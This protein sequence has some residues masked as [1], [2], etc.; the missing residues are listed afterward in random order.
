MLY[1]ALLFI[2]KAIESVRR[3]ITVRSDTMNESMPSMPPDKMPEEIRLKI[4]KTLEER[5]AMLPCPRCGNRSFILAD[6]FISP[7][8]Q[9][10][11]NTYVMGGRNIPAAIVVCDNCGYMSMHSVGVLDLMDELKAKR[12][13]E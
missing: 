12:D 9:T 3:S 8:I 5:G 2:K 7:S 13:G 1:K 6:G 11:L 4:Q 10:D